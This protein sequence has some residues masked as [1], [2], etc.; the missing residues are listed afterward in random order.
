MRARRS[1]APALTPATGPSAE[2]LSTTTVRTEARTSWVRSAAR[3]SGSR[4]A[5]FQVSTTACTR[6]PGGATPSAPL[7][8]V[9]INAAPL[10]AVRTGV[11]RYIAGLLDALADAKPADLRARPLFLPRAPARTLRGLIKRLPFAYPLAD[12]ARAAVLRRERPSVYHETNHAAPPFRGPVVLTV[13]D[14]STILYPRSQE[15][16][17]A[18]HFARKL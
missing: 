13:H 3:Q 5:P 10:A 17:R 18:R 12:A 15:R 14:L 11:G 6:G 1:A 4:C 9:A 2:A 8:D 7:L 16:A